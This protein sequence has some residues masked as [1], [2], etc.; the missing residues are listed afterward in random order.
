MDIG[1]CVMGNAL[2]RVVSFILIHDICL[3]ELNANQQ[4]RNWWH[5]G[6]ATKLARMPEQAGP[7]GNESRGDCMSV[8]YSQ[9]K[10]KPFAK[11]AEP[12]SRAE[13]MRLLRTLIAEL[14]NE[15]VPE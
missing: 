8:D 5:S 12:M 14:F 6:W 1:F 3:P 4:K 7:P 13:R 11:T 9:D 2:T 10:H 15:E